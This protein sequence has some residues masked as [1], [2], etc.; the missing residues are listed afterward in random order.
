MSTYLVVLVVGPLSHFDPIDVDGKLLRVVCPIGKEHLADYVLEVGAFALRFFSDW[1]GIVY[2]GDKLDLVAI[3]DFALGAMENLG[4]VTFPGAVR[5]STRRRSTQAELQAVVDVI[6]H[7]IAHMWFGD[8]VT[9]KWWNGIWLNE[10][11]A[12]FMEMTCTD[13]PAPTGSRTSGRRVLCGVRHRRA[14]GHP[15]DRVP[16]R[17]ARRRRRHVRRAQPR[18]GRIGRP[19]ARAVRRAGPLPRQIRRYMARHQYGNTETS[20]LWDALEAETGEPVRRIAELIFQGG[21]PEVSV[22]AAH[23]A[24]TLRLMQRRFRYVGDDGADGTGGRRRRP[25]VVGPGRGGERWRRRGHR[26]P[27]AA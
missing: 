25:P 18:E 13:A 23:G 21:F 8:L 1:F 15:A 26:R 4:C 19:H 10:A 14:G 11:F 9:M 2:P 24:S 7:E 17:L 12:T 6:A 20:D 27:P 3:P 22:E 5:W 16:G